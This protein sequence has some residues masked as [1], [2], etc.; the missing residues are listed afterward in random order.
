MEETVEHSRESVR[1]FIKAGSQL[2]G[3][4]SLTLEAV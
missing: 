1:Q 2:Y 3:S 4:I